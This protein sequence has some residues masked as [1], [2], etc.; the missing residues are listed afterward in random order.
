MEPLYHVYYV[1]TAL[2]PRDIY[3]LQ[4]GEQ[5]CTPGYGFGPCIRN[6]YF[7]HYVYQGKG[8]FEGEGKRYL[9]EAG[10]LFLIYPGQLTYYEADREEPWVYRWIEFNGSFSESLLKAA[11]LSRDTPVFMESPS[12]DSMFPEAAREIFGAIGAALKHLVTQGETSFEALMSSFWAFLAALTSESQQT[13]GIAPAEEYVRK[14][15][16]YIKM[17]LHQKISIQEIAEYVG[18]NRSYLSRLFRQYKGSSTQQYIIAARLDSAAQ[19]LKNKK[20]SVGEVAKSVGYSDQ[21]EFSKAFKARFKVS[22]TQWRTEVFWQ[23]SV[24][25]YRSEKNNAPFS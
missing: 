25:E 21:L 24:K 7:L 19:Y 4:Y 15:E 8:T 12:S 3:P 17:N 10:Q 1:D 11:G 9:L 22:P 6:H 5:E 18:I 2:L 14:A 13:A 16:N 20:L 23:Q